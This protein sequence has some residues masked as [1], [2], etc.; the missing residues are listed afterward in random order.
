MIGLEYIRKLNFDTAESLAGKLGVTKGLIS[1]WENQKT[2]IPQKRLK[3]LSKLYNAPIEYFSRPL[4]RI[5]KLHLN[6]LETIASLSKPTNNYIVSD[7]DKYGNKID[8]VTVNSEEVL[9]K[10]LLNIQG[11]IKFE[12]IIQ[13]LYDIAGMR[14]LDDTDYSPD[15]APFE[16]IASTMTANNANIFIIEKFTALMESEAGLLIIPATLKALELSKNETDSKI[17]NNKLINKLTAVFREW[18]LEEKKKAEIELSTFK[19]VFDIND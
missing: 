10:T 7:T 8:E 9:K 17:S 2:P 14:Y 3:D 15:L 16:I 1:Q 18:R 6:E 4:T 19:E 5:E 13:R 11:A 12:E